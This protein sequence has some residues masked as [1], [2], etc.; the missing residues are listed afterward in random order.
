MNGFGK[1]RFNIY[2]RCMILI[3]CMSPCVGAAQS[4]SGIKVPVGFE[5]V[6]AAGDELA[7]NIYC[8][9][10]S[11]QGET[12][13][14]GP[15]YIKVLVDSDGDGVFDVARPF[16]DRPQS[17]AQGICFDGADLLCTGDG[18]L[19][20]FSDA[21]GDGV[22]DG[23][24]T[25]IFSIK[26]GGEHDAHAIRKGPDGWWY[27]LAGN[28]VPILPEYFAGAN[29]PVTQP[30]AGFL[31]R[32]S[33]DWKEKEIF[34]HGFRNAYDF[35]FNS[36][37]QVFIY[38]SDGERDISLPWYRPTRVYQ[39]RAG[40]DAG[41]VAAG[42]KRPSAFFD[43]PIEIGALGRGSPTGVVVG[44]SKSFPSAFDDAVFVADWT[45]GR[46][47][48][49]RRDPRTQQYD[50][51]TDFAVARG[52]FGFAITDLDFAPDGSLL[53]SAGGRGTQG[54]IYRVRF[55]GQPDRKQVPTGLPEFVRLA[56]SERL[57]AEPLIEG[58]N[59]SHPAIQL[60]ALEALVGRRDLLRTDSN[61]GDWLNNRLGIG[62]HILL[63]TDDSKTLAILLRVLKD[64]DSETL[65]SLN[66]HELPIGSQLMLN[67]L[68][69]ANS[70]GVKSESLERV[71]EV[72]AKGESDPMQV[73]RI[74]QLALG[75]CGAEKS[76]Q[77]FVGYSARS[78]PSIPLETQK[79]IADQ[80]A[81]AINLA[82]AKSNGLDV[83][84][85]GAEEIGRLAAML[86]CGSKDLQFA[87]VDKL[88]RANATAQQDIHWLNCLT[89]IIDDRDRRLDEKLEP[90]VAKALVGVSGKIKRD[91][92]NIDRNFY[93]RMRSLTKRLC[94]R[95]GLEFSLMV[96]TQLDGSDDQVFL[97]ESLAGMA[98]D[99]TVPRFVANI[100]SHPD[101]VT[102]GQL[103]VIASHS[104]GI[105]L[106]LVRKFSDRA[107]LQ[108]VVIA[109]LVRSPMAEDRELF[110]R[111]LKAVNLKSVKNSAIGLRRLCD[112]PRAD[113]IVSAYA[114]M[115]RLVWDKPSVSVRDQLILLLQKETGKEF[116]FQEKRKEIVQEKVLNRWKDFVQ[117]SYPTEFGAA[118]EMRDDRELTQ[119]LAAIN[120]VDG[121]KGRGKKIY[122]SLQCAQCHDS[123]SRLGPRLEGVTKRF[124]RDDVFR[125]IVSPNDQVP[126][127]YRAIVIQTVDGQ[128]FQGG[129][130]Y[131]SVDGITLQEIGGNT[132]RIN[133]D[134]IESRSVSSKSLMPEGLLKESSDQDWSDLFAYLNL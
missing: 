13:V 47:V 92:Q 22:A 50:R 72:L 88:L 11:P 66:N 32:V 51:G 68:V 116:G 109:S 10:V 96:A 76:D 6:K 127:R 63:K 43:M 16:S 94:Q 83:N 129:M 30:R 45:F 121:D 19:W 108:D 106:P 95:A 113:E 29:S 67:T 104:G 5:I 101:H 120:W 98:K 23:T 103:N 17:G 9:A 37:G 20:R 117:T 114:A 125:A 69:A 123:G 48:A 102:A 126:D 57:A 21:D 55:V 52:Q 28:G 78:L 61:R 33:P 27:L 3:S 118:F 80:L 59:K 111:G 85:S 73:A 77:M 7:T 97:F 54:A 34:C 99:A 100:E 64:L 75:G 26:T 124:S 58:I 87:I 60:A 35:D 2:L 70:G 46:V 18:G 133:R 107:E 82:S 12:F 42:W 1:T 36:M 24:P 62:L 131:E 31:M 49:F 115:R 132:V 53:I 44:S 130:V 15:G 128:F 41:W 71:A 134:D 84:E 112:G 110:L 81:V 56:K 122:T 79:A 4:V 40:D 25:K 119:R 39:M 14:S 90:K 91:N 74:G 38:D 65:E 86:A 93:P 89:Q 105:Y 8:L